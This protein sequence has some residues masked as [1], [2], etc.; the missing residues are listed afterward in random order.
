MAFLTILLFHTYARP[1]EMFAVK[2][3]MLTAPIRN[4]RHQHWTIVLHPTEE[5]E[6]SKVKEWDETLPI[7]VGECR[8]MLTHGLQVLKA[9]RGREQ[10][11]F[12]FQQRHFAKEFKRAA[13]AAGLTRLQP[14]TYSLRHSGPSHDMAMRVRSLLEIKLRGRW[15]SDASLRRY[16]KEGRIAQQLASLTS[17]TRQKAIAAPAV[18]KRRLSKL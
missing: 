9:T 11:L 18:L 2:A 8:D 6:P 7:D 16:Q 17:D 12:D 4:T 10:Q 3:K 5:S 1:K 13:Q 14:H 15:K